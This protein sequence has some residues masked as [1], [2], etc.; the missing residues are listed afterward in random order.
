MGRKPKTYKLNQKNPVKSWEDVDLTLKSM[1]ELNFKIEEANT[2]FKR[3]VRELRM[4]S[5]NSIKPLKQEYA[6][7]E[8]NVKAFVSLHR[9]EIEGK[10][11]HLNFGKTGFRQSTNVV[12][13]QDHE[14]KKEIL[15]TLKAKKMKGA[16]IV[17]EKISREG[18]KRLNDKTLTELGVE[19]KKKDDFFLDFYKENV[20]YDG[21]K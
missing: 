14:K 9:E 3:Q 21:V 10:E 13:P 20:R 19:V 5:F 11:K 2:E 15:N 17:D 4:Q 1:C 8:N 12:L 6:E 7:H 16:I 18:L